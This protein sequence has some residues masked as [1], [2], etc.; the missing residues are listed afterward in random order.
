MTT[1]RIH[2]LADFLGDRLGGAAQ[3]YLDSLR[4]AVKFSC[5]EPALLPRAGL[6][7]LP[8]IRPPF[9]LTCLE[10]EFEA[11][12]IVS[13]AVVVRDEGRDDTISLWGASRQRGEHAWRL[14]SPRFVQAT[15]DGYRFL[16]GA[17]HH[18]AA[19]VY[20]GAA[21][22]V[23][24]VLRCVNVKTEQHAPDAKLNRKRAIAGKCPVFE[25]KTLA[26][27]VPNDRR[28]GTPGGGTHASPRLHLRRGHIRRLADGRFVW[29]RN[30]IVGAIDKGV[31]FKDYMLRPSFT[32]AAG[33]AA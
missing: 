20:L 25:Y 31:V 22:T 18:D 28:N 7:D 8:S 27:N 4:Q 14:L 5:G 15:A 1:T 2:D 30:T 33:S 29:V 3:P 11:G 16:G 21:L 32:M 23:F 12:P 26:I 9:E 6:R 10:F 24:Q 19:T 13:T 17:P